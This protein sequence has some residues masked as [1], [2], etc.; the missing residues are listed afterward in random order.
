M[1][2]LRKEL[3]ALIEKNFRN[4]LR[5]RKGGKQRRNCNIFAECVESGEISASGSEWKI[6]SD[7]LFVSCLNDGDKIA[8]PIKNYMDLF[9]NISINYMSIR[10]R[11]VSQPNKK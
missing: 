7:K 6:G 10:S 11:L 1:Q 5:T 8:K 2:E 3:N 4:L 9:I